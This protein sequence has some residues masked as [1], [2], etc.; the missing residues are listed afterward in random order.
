MREL[1]GQE[2]RLQEELKMHLNSLSGDIDEIK[3]SLDQLK[4]SQEIQTVTYNS[5]RFERLHDHEAALQATIDRVASQVPNPFLR[6]VLLSALKDIATEQ[7]SSLL[8]V[9]IVNDG[10]QP[11]AVNE[12][13]STR[14]GASV[15]CRYEHLELFE[16]DPGTDACQGSTQTSRNICDVESTRPKQNH[17]APLLRSS[18]TS[19]KDTIFGRVYISTASWE[20]G[21]DDADGENDDQQHTVKTT[22]RFHPSH[23]LLKCGLYYGLNVAYMRSE[24]GL[25]LTN[26]E[27]FR[28]VPDNALVFELARWGSLNAMRVMFADGR[29]SPLDTD[30]RGW[31]PLA[32]AAYYAQVP[33]C[34]WLLDKGSD[35]TMVLFSH[36][37]PW[38]KAE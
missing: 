8:E 17:R 4:I 9:R 31:T 35:R 7:I 15:P 14:G 5:T 27:A 16:G 20:S 19:V 37:S 3:N 10:Q 2:G 12:H 36:S 13:A 23:W 29:A 1:A 38:V 18:S 34:K 21:G 6:Q 33:T 11:S 32:W 24:R 30:S 26:L 25:K 28:A 22:I